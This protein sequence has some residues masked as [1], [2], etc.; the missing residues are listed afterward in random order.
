MLVIVL[1]CSYYLGYLVLLLLEIA[2]GLLCV[3]D[4]RN[5]KVPVIAPSQQSAVSR[6]PLFDGESF[7][8]FVG[9]VGVVGF[10]G[11]PPPTRR[12][13]SHGRHPRGF[14]DVRQCMP[15]PAWPPVGT[16]GGA[17]SRRGR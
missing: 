16:M 12:T 7:V 6:S 11:P 8:G 3:E 2:V 14:Q 17:R 15:V 5:K 4:G 13:F 9:V 1:I 10:V